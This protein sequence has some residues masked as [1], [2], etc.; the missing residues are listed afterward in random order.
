[1]DSRDVDALVSRLRAL[2]RD[3][4]QVEAKSCGPRLST[5]VWESVSAFANTE[6][7]ILL[8]GLDEREGFAPVRGFD[9]DRT[10]SQFVEGIGDGGIAGAKLTNPPRYRASTALVDGSAVLAV[11]ISENPIGTKP[12]FISAR[13]MNGG[14]FKRVGDKDIRLS[15]TEIFEMQMAMTPSETDREVVPEVE[16]DDLDE[17]LVDRY[18]AANADSRALAGVSRDDRHAAL[19][20]LNIIA[21]GGG[22]RFAALLTMGRYPQQY[23][24]QLMI[25]VAVHPT[26]D[27]ASAGSTTR[28]LDRQLCEGPLA[29]AV[30]AAVHAVTRN[31]RTYSTIEG[32]GRVD[33]L[34]IPREVLREG[35][36]NAVLHREYHA[37]FQGQPVS[38]DVFPDRVEITSP[39]ALWGGKTV[40][41]LTDGQSRCRNQTLLQILR[42]LPL[43][44]GPGAVVEGNGS[45]IAFMTHQMSAHALPEPGFRAL[46]DSVVLTLAR[47]AVEI[48]DNR[49]W[50][51]QFADRGLSR[52]ELST[53]MLAMS[54]PGVS[55]QV[56]RD[57]LQIDS[58]EIRQMLT[59][60][61]EE[62]I[63]RRDGDV[64]WIAD[65][66]AAR[67]DHPVLARGRDDSDGGPPRGDDALLAAISP[68]I[69]RSVHEIAEATGRT[70][71]AIRPV[72]RRLVADGHVTATA[73]P[74]SRNRRYL[75]ASD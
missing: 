48:P 45:G 9:L 30:D 60:L 39:G 20:R 23:L 33:Q 36:A 22:V 59:N 21:P 2:G 70:V 34:E 15:S 57:F 73:P 38:V 51:S 19:R 31:L 72:L 65:G 8:L 27:R 54:L 18:I 75:R 11:E 44:D 16:V 74:T 25:D 35:I 56:L 61:E 63:L 29:D 53:L 68:T 58:D 32:S 40:E 6:G 28:F 1:M 12:C 64:W 10:L 42:K 46:P 13:S 5:D 26:P 7:G 49:E 50:L 4:E 62:R 3:D 17:A 69:P 14:A 71:A 47:H 41:T 43:S 66:A 24:P 67:R 55:V 37:L 52:H